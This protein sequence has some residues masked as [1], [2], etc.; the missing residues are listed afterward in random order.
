MQ[1]MSNIAPIPLVPEQCAVLRHCRDAFCKAVETK[2]GCTAI[3]HNLDDS[4]S[5]GSNASNFSAPELRYFKKLSKGVKVSV[6]KDDLTRHKVDAV[7]NAANEG[8]N[9]GAGLALALCEAGGPMIQMWS[10]KIIGKQGKVPTGTAVSTP[11]GNLP[12]K[13]IIHA[14]GPHLPSNPTK[15]DVERFAPILHK[16]IKSI[17]DVVELGKLSSVAIPAI[18]SGLFN[19]PRH[20][21]ANIIVQNVQDYN[22]RNRF[23]GRVVE[24]NLV[25]N[26]EPTVQEMERACKEILGAPNIT[27]SYSGA[28]TSRDQSFTSGNSFQFGNVTLHITK[29][30]IEEQMVD[31]IVNTISDNLDLSMGLVSKAIFEK[32]GQKIQEELYKNKKHF[33]AS[34]DVFVTKGHSLNCAAVYHTVCTLRS[35]SGAKQI[36]Y[37]VV[38]NCLMKAVSAHKSISFPAIGTGNLGF[39]KQEVA[40]I[41]V[42]AVAEFANKNS[43][44]KLDINFVVFPKDIEMMEAFKNKLDGVKGQMKFDSAMPQS[45]AFATNESKRNETPTLEISSVSKEALREAQAWIMNMLG[46]RNGTI[47]IM[48]NYVIY[49][50]QKDHENLLSLQTLLGVHITVFFKNGNGGI[51]IT[52][53]PI[54]VSCGAIEVESMLCQAQKDFALDEESDL[55]Y[56]VVRWQCKAAPWPPKVNAALEKSYLARNKEIE[57]DDYNIKVNLKSKFVVDIFGKTSSVERTCMFKDYNPFHLDSNSFYARTPVD[58]KDFWEMERKVKDCGLCTIRVEKIENAALQQIFELNRMRIKDKPE[59]LY[60]CVSAQFCD[61]ICRVGF[62]KDFAPPA[63]QKDGSGIYFSSRLDRALKLWNRQNEEYIYIIQAQV[64]TGKSV[65]GSPDFILPPVMGSDPLKRFDSLTDKENTHVIFNGQQALPQYLIIC[66]K[67]T[68]SAV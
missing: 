59:H 22:D 20:L 12:C 62:H 26:D 15:W 38:L 13:N 35:G 56:S 37:E 30:L 44:K 42:K 8:L 5:S 53:E 6:W 34:G 14:V 18:S 25:N 49:F 3:I 39:H 21:C 29:G 28:V 32:A 64:L 2:F 54:P 46:P 11:A 52:G 65:I 66:G 57:L 61:L 50:G 40:E 43:R 47:T 51:I 31:V 1:A 55:L 24:I 67:P 45:S 7:V 68:L 58:G 48:N 33:V 41:M 60:Q 36:L 23:N 27:G 9:H 10:D 4:D 19:F 16:T 17:L 63:E